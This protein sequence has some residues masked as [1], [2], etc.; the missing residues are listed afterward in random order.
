MHLKEL[1][2]ASCS[3]YDPFIG[4]KLRS[5]FTN[6]GLDSHVNLQSSIPATSFLE[7]IY[8]SDVRNLERFL[9]EERKNDLKELKS[10]LTSINTKNMFSFMP[11]FFIL[12]RK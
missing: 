10:I 7:Q 9:P 12:A 11:V 6:L 3:A 5:L 8:N 4:R 2:L 1:L